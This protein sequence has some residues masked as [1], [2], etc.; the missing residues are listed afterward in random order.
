M[1][2]VSTRPPVST[3]PHRSLLYLALTALLASVLFAVP[4]VPARAATSTTISA[5]GASGGRPDPDPAPDPG[6]D[7]R[8]HQLATNFGHIEA[9][10]TPK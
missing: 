6:P 3:A 10:Y 2:T 5:N 7:P 8:Q 4:G 1:S 9:T